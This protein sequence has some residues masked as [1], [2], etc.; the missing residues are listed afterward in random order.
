MD[1]KKIVDERGAVYGHP[2]D[3]FRRIQAMKAVIRECRDVEVREALEMI[4]V[5]VARLI[6]TPDHADTID[7]I[8]G[9][10]ETIRMI[11]EARA[12]K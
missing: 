6:E 12:I 1:I 5:K 3:S 2:I 4:A 10:A 7:D 9:Y 8:C 11:H